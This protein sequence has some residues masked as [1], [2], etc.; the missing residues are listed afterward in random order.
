MKLACLAWGSL[1]WD[2]RTLPCRGDFREDGPELPIDFSRVSLD[3]RVTL[4]IDPSA[5]LLQTRWVEL[6]VDGM[7][8]AIF[9]LGQREKIVPERRREWVGRCLLEDVLGHSDLD[10]E[11][12]RGAGDPPAKIAE[13]L[14]ARGLDGLVWTALP[15]RGPQG[16]PGFPAID[17]LVA[18]L[19]SLVGAARDRAEEYIRRAPSCV[20]TERRRRFEAEFGWRPE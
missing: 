20:A 8:E 14:G 3:G 11:P 16:E 12:Q 18:H 5:P 10:R 6:D 19:E 2:P 4:V 1:V 7:D 13:W 15:G 9:E 17:E